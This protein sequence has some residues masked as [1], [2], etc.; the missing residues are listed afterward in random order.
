MVVGIFMCADVHRT[1][2]RLRRVFACFYWMTIRN[3]NEVT[4]SNLKT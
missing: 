4:L 3:T 2:M 1:R